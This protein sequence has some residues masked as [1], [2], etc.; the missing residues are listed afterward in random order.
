MASFLV[1]KLP[2]GLSGSS[3]HDKPSTLD[4]AKVTKKERHAIRPPV[5]HDWSLPGNLTDMKAP[6][7]FQHEL[8]ENFS[9]NMFCKVWNSI[10]QLVLSSCIHHNLNEISYFSTNHILSVARFDSFLVKSDG[11]S[12]A[13]WV[14]MN[15]V[16]NFILSAVA[17]NFF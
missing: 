5:E 9:I 11:M 4:Q 8:L 13:R 15:S 7:I 1:P 2:V 14:R 6:Q 16:V 12:W 3:S 10:M 17:P